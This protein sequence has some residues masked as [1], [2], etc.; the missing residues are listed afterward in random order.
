MFVSVFGRN[1]L[2]LRVVVL[3]SELTDEL[4]HLGDADEFDAVI[5]SYDV[6]LVDFYV[7]WWGPCQMM[8]PTIEALADDTLAETIANYTP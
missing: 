5:D 7:D 1:R 4:S 6:V 2:G 3:G 8:E